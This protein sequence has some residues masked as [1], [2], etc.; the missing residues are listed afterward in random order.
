MTEAPLEQDYDFIIVGAGSAG[1]VLAERLTRSG[2]HRVLLLEAGG[3]DRKFWIKL[4]VGYAVTFAMAA[5]NW[6]DH[7]APDVALN[8]RSIYW[9]RGRVLGGSSSI[10][11][12]AYVRGLPHDFDDW[13]RAGAEGWNWTKVRDTYQALETHSDGTGDG[14]VWVQDLSDQMHPFS[15]HFLQAAQEAG[16]GTA[17]DMNAEG[18]EG[19]SHYRST[20]RGGM[21]WSSADAFLRPA[22]RRPNLTLLTRAEVQGLDLEGARVVGLQYTRG[23]QLCTARAGEVILS[24]GAI[25]SPQL[26]QLSGIGPANLLREHGIE[27]RH[28]L[29]EVGEGLQDHLAISWQFHAREQTLNAVLGTLSGRLR[30]GAAYA[31]TGRGPL[32]V[33]VNQIG[34]FVRSGADA[35]APNLQLFCNPASYEITPKGKVVMDRQ[36]GY[37]LS[38]QPCRPTSRGRIRIRSADPRERPL[39]EANSLAT[40]EDRGMAVRASRVLQRLA[41]TPA[42]RAV[43]SGCKTKGFADMEDEALLEAFRAR[44]STVY[45]PTCTC[46]MGEGPQDSVVDGRLRVHGL[47]GLRVVDA[48]AFPNITSGNTN[49][50]TMMLAARAADLILQDSS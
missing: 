27:V 42:L 14:P 16:L 13:A 2:R 22:L 26:L 45:H 4:P 43:T 1:C 39:I 34:G 18:A 3:S 19:L 37:L 15:D 7:A 32:S 5:L 44:A 31:L 36:Q 24:A 47:A 8:G 50:P 11:A 21:R 23:G 12:M 6:G 49:A 38:A 48:S 46:R 25:N 9:P 10:N 17:K 29:P 41:E 40:P 33:P 20:V 28:N 30:A 35:Q